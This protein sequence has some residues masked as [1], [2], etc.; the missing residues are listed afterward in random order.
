MRTDI[1][2]QRDVE[3]TLRWDPGLMHEHGAVSVRDGIVAL[4]GRVSCFVDRW[5]AER[6]AARVKGVRGLANDLEVRLPPSMMRDDAVLLNAIRQALDW[7]LMVPHQARAAVAGGWVT[8]TGEVVWNF[9]RDAAERAIRH[10]VGIA[11]VT[12]AMT[13]R[14]TP[15][16]ADLKRKIVN[17]L[18]R[19][20]AIDDIRITV[21]VHGDRAILRGTVRSLI[22]R[23]DAERAVANTPGVCTVENRLSVDPNIYTPA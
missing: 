22:E 17:A 12:N 5:R 14:V 21:E 8:L 23:N 6:L 4:V 15:A 10:L 9:Q 20:A 18:E 1:E 11:G 19:D 2:I 3:E 7:D 16:S 13:V